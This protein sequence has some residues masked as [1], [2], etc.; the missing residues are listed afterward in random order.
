MIY[1]IIDLGSNTIR[2]SIFKYDGEKLKLLSNKKEI[3]GLALCVENGRLTEK[4]IEK[5][6]EILNKYRESLENAHVK[7][8]S[9]FATASLRNIKNKEEVLL[10][11]KNRTGMEPEILFGEEEARLGFLA[12]KNE[13]PIE[14]GIVIDIG[15]GSTEIV[16]FEDGEI[17]DLTSLPIGAL[18]LQ[19]RNVPGLVA[20]EK[21]IKRMR[22]IVS[23]ALDK[24]DWENKEY[25]QMYAVG[26]TARAALKVA[27][28]LFEI[29]VESKSFS[30]AE[31]KGIVR[32]MKSENHE[33]YKAVY[34]VVPERIFSFA[35]GISILS[36]IVKKFNCSFINISKSGIREGYFIDRIV[37]YKKESQK[38]K[39]IEI[40]E[41]LEN[42]VNEKA[43]ENF[44]N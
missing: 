36:E 21:D 7:V 6:C 27:K 30:R 4:G 34:K 1:G 31:L 38:V 17:R 12:V 8:Y 5:T 32:K 19:D 2:L 25:T 24:L 26:G 16:V 29:P 35:G 41:Q 23:K 20:K 9:V 42:E 40:K 18:N 3:V 44:G 10:E 28:E 39:E 22:R 13:Y 15:G 14:N 37:N 11:I 43:G 33:E